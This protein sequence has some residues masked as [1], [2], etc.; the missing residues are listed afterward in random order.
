MPKPPTDGPASL[1][2]LFAKLSLATEANDYGQVLRVADAI[3][4]SS[5][6]DLRAAKQ[7][8]IALIKLDKYA[9][10]LTFLSKTTHLSSSTTV[11]ERSFCLY[12]LGRGEEVRTA[13]ESA[14][15]IVVEHIRAQ[16]VLSLPPR[17]VP[18][19]TR[20]IVWKTLL[21]PCDSTLNC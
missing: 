6:T 3:L 14:S 19:D 1:T 20:H 2:Q 16:N 8:L 13:L 5:P 7:K 9:E 21:L 12:K 11:L 18:A 17:C 4:Q 10:A 15:G